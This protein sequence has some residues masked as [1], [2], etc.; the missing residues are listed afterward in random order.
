MS[1]LQL[2]KESCSAFKSLVFKGTVIYLVF[3]FH[4][5]G[6][7]SRRNRAV[8]A[9]IGIGRRAREL[10]WGNEGTTFLPEFG[11]NYES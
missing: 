7:F 1:Y 3:P 8:A 11:A 2:N 10:I 5:P 4:H 6:H 9:P